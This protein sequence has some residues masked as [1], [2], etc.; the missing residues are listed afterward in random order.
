[1]ESLKFQGFL[2]FLF[3]L[4]IPTK[5]LSI[6]LWIYWTIIEQVMKFYNLSDKTFEAD[7]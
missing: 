7:L 2:S 3:I 5:N 4:S 6:T 1:M